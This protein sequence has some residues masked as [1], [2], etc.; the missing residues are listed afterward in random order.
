MPVA[1]RSRT[2]HDADDPRGVGNNN[3]LMDRRAGFL[4]V[5]RGLMEPWDGPGGHRLHRRQ[6]DRRDP[7]PKRP[8]PRPLLVTTDDLL[9]MGSEDR[10]AADRR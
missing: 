4:R 6:A 9:I 10:R 7:G 5:S 2:R 3:P 8:A 1:T